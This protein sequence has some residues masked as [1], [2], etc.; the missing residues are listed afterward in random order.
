[1]K[2]RAALKKTLDRLYLGPAGDFVGGRNALAKEL[3][4]DGRED[5]A[6]YVRGMTKPTVAATEV[7]RLAL[8]HATEMNAFAKAAA[9]LREA[10]KGKGALRDAVRA[11]RDALAKLLEAV[12]DSGDAAPSAAVRDR[13][14]ETLH[15]VAAD[16]ALEDLV[17]KGRLDKERSVA[18]FGFE[19]SGGDDPAPSSP[20]ATD[21]KRTKKER[22]AAEKAVE[23]ARRELKAAES[24]SKKMQAAV[25]E[26]K[27][28]LERAHE[29]AEEAQAEV[30]R[31]ERELDE[32]ESALADID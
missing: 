17:A 3:K 11:E 6:D 20:S 9:A 31:A 19:L 7:N 8:E 5:E 13:I 4:A 24:D 14:T 29:R 27:D 16:P 10:P 32:R 2:E 15:A 18:G 30:V 22:A 28:R 25:S 1:M 26:A 23:G 12:P 21:D